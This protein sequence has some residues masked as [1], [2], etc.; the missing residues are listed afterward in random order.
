MSP[1]PVLTGV[2]PSD[3]VRDGI[4]RRTTNPL[5]LVLIGSNLNN[6]HVA[7]L[8]RADL[9]ARTEVEAVSVL[10]NASQA[11]CT[12]PPHPAF[13]EDGKWDATVVDDTGRSSTKS[14]LITIRDH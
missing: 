1:A 10:S 13:D 11:F 3:L 14:S 6:V 12:F 2:Q 5:Q 4:I 8:T 9:T 7:R